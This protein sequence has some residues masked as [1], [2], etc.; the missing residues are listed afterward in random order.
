MQFGSQKWYLGVA[1]KLR[2]NL[3]PLPPSKPGAADCW[4]RDPFVG[5]WPFPL[6]C[7][8]CKAAKPLVEGANSAQGWRATP[9]CPDCRRHV[10]LVIRGVT[11]LA[12]RLK[13]LDNPSCNSM[14]RATHRSDETRFPFEKRRSELTTARR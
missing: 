12:C 3:A 9:G 6:S 10:V 11:Q 1:N 8:G 14:V 5:D 2:E 13:T 4:L 7:K